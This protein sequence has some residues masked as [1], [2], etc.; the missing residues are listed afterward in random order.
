[1]TDAFIR[2]FHGGG[3]T[4]FG[5][6]YSTGNLWIHLDVYSAPPLTGEPHSRFPTTHLYRFPATL[7]TPAPVSRPSQI[8]VLDY[9]PRPNTLLLNAFLLVCKYL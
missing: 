3:L 4:H 9:P 8:Y 2:D 6:D 7:S 5:P 1:M